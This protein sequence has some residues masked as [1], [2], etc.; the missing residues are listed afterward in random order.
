MWDR[1]KSKFH[2]W[3][4]RINRQRG[5]RAFPR[6]DRFVVGSDPLARLAAREQAY[7]IAVRQSITGR[8]NNAN[9]PRV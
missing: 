9:G 1:S 2:V 6:K 7:L 4:K 3:L 8:E 5:V